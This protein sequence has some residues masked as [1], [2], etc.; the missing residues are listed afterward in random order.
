M[1]ASGVTAASA[2]FCLH[3]RAALVFLPWQG[4]GVVHD[5]WSNGTY[6]LADEAIRLL[7]L[8]QAQGEADL[9]ALGEATGLAPPRLLAL[10]KELQPLGLVRPC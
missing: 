4:G 8:L 9:A 1:S 2:R 10:L 3:A 7:T 5:A 6:L